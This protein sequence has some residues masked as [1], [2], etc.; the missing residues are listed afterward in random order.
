M[1]QKYAVFNEQ[2]FPIAFYN[3]EIHTNIPAE[4]IAISEQ[5]WLEFI[6]N[7]GQ[8]KWNF[9]TNQIEVYTP[10]PPTLQEAQTQK[11]EELLL[12]QRE[13]LQV[14]LDTY[15]Y[16]GLADVQLYASQNVTEAQTILNWYQEYDNQIWNY[17]DVD[18]QAFTIV[19]E[20]LA[21]DMRVIEE[22]IYQ[23]SLQITPLP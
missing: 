3:D 13:R 5:D 15:G 23:S 20:L 6:D 4:A 17:I 12:L 1:G 9:Q 10:P 22:Q 8:R 19:D 2:G 7:Q 14:V 18:L 16:N 11:Q 21:L